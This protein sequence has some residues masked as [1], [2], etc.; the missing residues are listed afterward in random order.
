RARVFRHLK[1]R[2][3]HPPT[4]SKAPLIKWQKGFRY[5]IGTHGFMPPLRMSDVQA[6]LLHFKFLGDFAARTKAEAERGEHFD[7]ARE[8]KAYR[9]LLEQDHDIM[10][11]NDK[12]VRYENSQQLLSLGLIRSSSEYESYCRRLSA[13]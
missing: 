13:R 8:Y 1:E 6:A 5:T 10:L 9:D 12:S 2:G 11:K 4:V 3:Y 7:H